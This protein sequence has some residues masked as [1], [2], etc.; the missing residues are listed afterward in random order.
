MK[1]APIFVRIAMTMTVV[2]ALIAL[3]GCGG[4]KRDASDGRVVLRVGHFPNITHAQGLVAHKMSR[5]GNG[6]FEQRLGGDVVIEWYVYNAGPTAM[7][8]LLN[9]SLDITYVG[10]NPALN[11]HIRSQGEEIRV[12]AGAAEG[13]AALVVHGDGSIRT[14]EDFRG[15]RIA[16]PQLGNTQDVACRAWLTAQG[17]KVTETGG[18]VLVVPTANPDQ[19]TLF[20]KGDLAG[21]WTVEPWV[22]RLEMEAAGV[23][24]I[25]QPD[26]L[27][28]IL[29]T[30]VRAQKKSPELIRKFAAAHRELTQ[31]IIDHPE[32]AKRLMREELSAEMQREVAADLVEHA[33]PRL[34]F[35]ADVALDTFTQ[36]VGDAQSAGFLPAD[37]NISRLVETP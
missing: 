2:A 15:K 1:K 19:I 20:T 36:F 12:I 7:E 34:H 3:P 27:T 13:G 21:V 4:E 24:Y 11:A 8:A 14:P 16:T 35:T 26:A 5:D 25:K 22:S 10:P 17:F 37:V 23:I 28:T 29:T 31:W 9:G 32:D 6:W 18:D 33:W 30:S